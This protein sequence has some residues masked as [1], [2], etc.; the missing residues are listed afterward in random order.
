MKQHLTHMTSLAEQL[1]E[2]NEEI[3][4]KKF[5]TTVLESLPE[6]YDTF[7]QN[8]RKAEDLDWDNVKALLME[9]HMK[10]KEKTVKQETKNAL[11]VK[12]GKQ[13]QGNQQSRG[14]RG[15]GRGRNQNTDNNNK[16]AQDENYAEKMKNVQCYRCV[17]S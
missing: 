9:E 14:G 11:F 16:A 12:K 15:G 7:L 5:A 3:S 10:R 1:R 17:L 6:S 13:Q 2:L 8:A 4:S